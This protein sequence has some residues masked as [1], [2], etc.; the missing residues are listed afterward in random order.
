METP[1]TMCI[2]L[3]GRITVRGQHVYSDQGASLF[4]KMLGLFLQKRLHATSSLCVGRVCW[5][6][7]DTQS[8]GRCENGQ[9]CSP[10][11]AVAAPRAWPTELLLGLLPHKPPPAQSCAPW[12]RK[13][14]NQNLAGRIAFYS[15]ST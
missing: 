2:L 7:E 13:H 1:W 15:P 6:L 11:E 4:Q 12:Q 9:G 14:Q 8:Q 3:R 10:G 5:V